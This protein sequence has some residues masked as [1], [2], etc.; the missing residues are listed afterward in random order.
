MRHHHVL[1]IVFLMICVTGCHQEKDVEENTLRKPT[2]ISVPAIRLT[3]QYAEKLQCP[4]LPNPPPQS[5]VTYPQPISAPPLQPMLFKACLNLNETTNNT[6]KLSETSQKIWQDFQ[7][8]VG[9]TPKRPDYI[10]HDFQ[11]ITIT[12]KYA[13]NSPQAK[14]IMQK[15]SEYLPSSEK[16]YE[17][18]AQQDL[19]PD[20]DVTVA[21]VPRVN[22][23][24]PNERWHICY[25][26]NGLA[27]LCNE[28]IGCQ[29]HPDDSHDSIKVMY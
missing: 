3:S 14:Q 17:L 29:C 21:I 4:I 25:P 22:S 15:L 28:K 16:I 2:S 8:R 27:L 5:I 23:D 6:I 24:M 7:C 18:T 10:Q 9:Y 20:C 19:P 12:H 26:D 13:K 1:S 11:A